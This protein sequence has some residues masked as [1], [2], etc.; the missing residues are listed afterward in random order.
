M[1]ERPARE[2][3]AQ[4]GTSRQTVLAWVKAAG[5][6]RRGRGGVF[7]R[8][9]EE[10]MKVLYQDGIPCWLIA[11]VFNVSTAAVTRRMRRAGFKPQ[12][13]RKCRT[14]NVRR[15]RLSPIS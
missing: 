12:G 11:K 4:F 5:L 15:H 10:R 3:G 8:L 2:I 6:P 7:K 13:G 9:N 14:L 1:A